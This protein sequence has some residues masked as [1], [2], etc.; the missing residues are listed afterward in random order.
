MSLMMVLQLAARSVLGKDKNGIL[1]EYQVI[2]GKGTKIEQLSRRS[3]MLHVN[4][5]MNE[6]GP[7]E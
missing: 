2:I 1:F 5:T 7:G 4:E 3:R 6:W